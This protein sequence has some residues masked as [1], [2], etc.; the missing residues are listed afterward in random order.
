MRKAVYKD[1][2]GKT[3]RWQHLNGHGW[4]GG[5]GGQAPGLYR[6]SAIERADPG[7]LVYLSESEKDAD[8]LAGLGLLATSHPGGATEALK[9]DHLKLLA[10][11]QV[12]ILAH[13]DEPG[14][15][16]AREQGQ[17]L[18]QA[19][20]EVR[21]VWPDL[22]GWD[23][24]VGGDVADLVARLGSAE[25]DVIREILAQKVMAAEVIEAERDQSAEALKSLFPHLTLSQGLALP[26]AD[27]LVYGAIERAD[28]GM[29]Y[30]DAS[31]GKTYLSVDLA[32]SLAAGLPWLT[33]WQISEPRRVL[34]FIAEGR[35]AFFRRVLAAVNGMGKRGADVKRVYELVE[36]NLIIVPEVPQLFMSDA[37]RYVTAYV[38]LWQMMGRPKIDIFF[39]DT[40]ARASTG[41]DE[42]HSKDAGIVIDALTYMQKELACA[43]A[44]VHHSNRAGGYRGSSAYRG[45]VDFVLKVEG[46][47]RE[48]RKLTIDKIRDG[49]LDGPGAG[50]EYVAV[51]QSDEVSGQSYTQWLTDDEAS[52]F[53]AKS[54]K[55]DTLQPDLE[56][57]IADNPGLSQNQI[58]L[59]CDGKNGW[60][61]ASQKPVISALNTLIRDGKITQQPGARGA[62][63]YYSSD[64]GNSKYQS[65]KVEYQSR[66]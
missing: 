28:L 56:R 35:K 41:A 66:D 57:C 23:F 10:G 63:L 26:E 14:R 48:P 49:E 9:P 43:G 32:V 11:R 34:Y 46:I 12:A 58:V 19:G 20:A 31:A 8:V 47:Y 37:Q 59:N 21:I 40:L 61:K 27:Y 51:F 7:E 36:Q 15:K 6:Q 65:T 38:E 53:Q 52:E 54:L 60:P 33:R 30:G 18:A 25:A 42:N 50:A 22:G 39:V 16:W 5:Y 24:A 45:A 64:F 4:Q 44:F 62:L 2:A 3:C 13:N 55:K 17:A 29:I 1:G